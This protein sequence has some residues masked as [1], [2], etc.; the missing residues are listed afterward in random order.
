MDAFP[1]SDE[2]AYPRFA[3]GCSFSQ[4]NQPRILMFNRFDAL[5][6]SVSC[7][8]ICFTIVNIINVAN[9]II[10]VIY[11]VYTF[12]SL[13]QTAYKTSIIFLV[14]G[15]RY[16][17]FQCFILYS[18]QFCRNSIFLC[19]TYES[20]TT[21]LMRRISYADWTGAKLMRNYYSNWNWLELVL[22]WFDKKVI[23]TFTKIYDLQSSKI[24]SSRRG[25]YNYNNE[26]HHR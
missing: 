26:V 16:F 3:I 19:I 6:D 7:C 21:V 9:Y 20:Q 22:I 11:R 4:R 12:T 25:V 10:F 15:T 14:H 23:W 13:I 8:E 1:V 2:R 24:N 5:N 18:L 17:V